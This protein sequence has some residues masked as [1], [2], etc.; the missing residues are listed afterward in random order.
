MERTIEISKDRFRD[1]RG[2]G[3][4][5]TRFRLWIEITRTAVDR[6]PKGRNWRR[7]QL[8][9]RRLDNIEA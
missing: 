4:A 3:Y 8:D 5:V 2:G 6:G 1:I 9:R 7:V